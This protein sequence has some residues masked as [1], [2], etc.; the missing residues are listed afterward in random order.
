MMK[1]ENTIQKKEQDRTLETNLNEMKMY[2]VHDREFKVSI[3]KMLN[4]IR[5][6]MHEQSENFKN[7]DN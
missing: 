6:K 3:I 5:R 1:K 2:E 4:E 7:K